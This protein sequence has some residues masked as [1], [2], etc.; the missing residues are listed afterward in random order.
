MEQIC[1]GIGPNIDVR[2]VVKQISS[3]TAAHE[4]GANRPTVDEVFDNYMIDE[5][6]TAPT[7]S[8]IG[9][10]DDVL[11]AGTHFRAM[12]RKLSERWPE[13]PI[14]GIFIARRVFA[15]DDPEGF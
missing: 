7:P 6:L 3:T 2:S 5:T 9:I 10:V 11:T 14:I 8:T 1:R 15:N 4:A 12:K 13:L